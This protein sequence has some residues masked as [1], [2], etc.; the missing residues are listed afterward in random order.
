MMHCRIPPRSTRHMTLGNPDGMMRQIC[1][2]YLAWLNQVKEYRPWPCRCCPT[3]AGSESNPC[4]PN[5]D[6]DGFVTPAASSWRNE[7]P[8]SVSSSC[9][10]GHPLG[11]PVPGAGLRLRYDLL[12]ALLAGQRD[13]GSDPQVAAGRASQG[14]RDRRV[15]GGRRVG[16]WEGTAMPHFTHEEVGTGE[17]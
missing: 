6:R 17:K 11:G 12:A 4:C 16:P 3:L 8:R 15:A 10:N 13:L 1:A 14:G 9:S 5:P 2:A 7:W